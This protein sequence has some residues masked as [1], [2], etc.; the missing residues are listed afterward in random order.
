MTLEEIKKLCMPKR[1]PDHGSRLPGVVMS[2][3]RCASVAAML[4]AL[5][6]DP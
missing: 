5:E 4:D 6:T 3:A 2:I 1:R